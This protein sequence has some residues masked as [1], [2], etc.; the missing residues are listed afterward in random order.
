M[1]IKR[2]KNKLEHDN[3][4]VTFELMYIDDMTGNDLYTGVDD[5]N[6]DNVINEYIHNYSEEDGYFYILEQHTKTKVLDLQYLL[7]AKKYNI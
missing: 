1:K 7:D 5:E 6:I 2:F 4:K 3:E